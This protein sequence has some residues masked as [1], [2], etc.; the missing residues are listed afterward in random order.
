M[1]NVNFLLKSIF[2]IFASLGICTTASAVDVVFCGTG[3]YVKRVTQG[4]PHENNTIGITIKDLNG[5]ET[6]WTS[7]GAGDANSHAWVRSLLAMA[8]TA[9]TNQIFVYPVVES[10]HCSD[11][12]V[13]ADTR[14]WNH[15]WRG[16]IFESGSPSN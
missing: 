5:Q 14:R 9:H 11:Q 16:L 13:A 6:S 3:G 15:Y 1:K 2:F 4:W 10:G 12:A 7:N 8:M